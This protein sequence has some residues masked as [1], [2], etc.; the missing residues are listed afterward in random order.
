MPG[1]HE[2]APRAWR[3]QDIERHGLPRYDPGDMAGIK[4][5]LSH[6]AGFVLV[7]GVAEQF[8]DP[9]DAL[10]RFGEALGRLL[11]Q[12]AKQETLVEISDFSDKDAFDDRG[13]RSPGKLNPHTDP[14][15]LIALLCVCPARR[16]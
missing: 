4:R 12:N 5:E 7:R 16:P 6:G 14:P 2:P 11:P 3:R 10:T 13:Y 1:P 15:L 8:A 9:G